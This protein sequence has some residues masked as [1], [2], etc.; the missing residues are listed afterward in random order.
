M[1]NNKDDT[2]TSITDEG[3]VTDQSSLIS[4]R[5]SSIASLQDKGP[6]MYNSVLM[7]ILNNHQAAIKTTC[8]RTKQLSFKVIN[9]CNNNINKYAKNYLKNKTLT[10]PKKEL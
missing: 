8:F 1:L 9:L 7:K 4:S 5:R 2:E 6:G 10:G 3:I